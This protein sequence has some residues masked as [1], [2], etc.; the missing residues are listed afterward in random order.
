MLKY[1]Q[2][3][4]ELKENGIVI[5]DKLYQIEHIEQKFLDAKVFVFP[6]PDDYQIVGGSSLDEL[7]TSR[8][9]LPFKTCFFETLGREVWS[10]FMGN[11]DIPFAELCGLFVHEDGPE[12]FTVNALMNMGQGDDVNKKVVAWY[13]TDKDQHKMLLVLINTLLD[14]LGSSVIAE[15]SDRTSLKVKGP[16]GK[17]RHRVGKFFV[18]S[19]KKYQNKPI[20]GFPY[21]VDWSHRWRVR[22]HWRSIPNK[23]GKDRDGNPIQGFTWI[24][25]H[26]KGPETKELI[27]K[28]RIIQ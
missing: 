2:F 16:S 27:E 3:L 4:N 13:P 18:V 17:V 14:R 15:S 24:A 22:G 19:T 6:K 9:S 23:I 8:P 26:I 1:T 10:V 12:T 28:T 11:K 20:P 5:G 25:D 7:N 21:S